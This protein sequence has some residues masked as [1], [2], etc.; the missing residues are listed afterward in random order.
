LT[1]IAA[2]PDLR[3]NV[4][5][6]AGARAVPINFTEIGINLARIDWFN[7]GRNYDQLVQEAANEA[8][9]NAFV[10]EYAR[11]G[12]TGVAWFTTSGVRAALENATGGMDVLN[13]LRGAGF[14]PTG[15]L[16]QVL[17][18]HIPLPATLAAQGATEGAFYTSPW[19]FTSAT[20]APFDKAAFMA[21][22]ETSVLGPLD[23]LR[24]TFERVPYLTRLGT[25][26]SPDEMNVD[27]LFVPNASLPEVAP[28]HMAVGHV[29][30]GDEDHSSC[31]APLRLEIED[32]RSVLFRPNGACRQYD[33]AA[34]DQMPASDVGFRRDPDGEGTREVDNRAAIE[35]AVSKHNSAVS[36]MIDDGCGCT[37]RGKGR[38]RTLLG[39]AALGLLAL[40]LRRRIG[41]RR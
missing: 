13:A 12:R 8:R 11:G 7:F 2:T 26:I 32:G 33:R 34:L 30:C 31:D 20:F 19:M 3:I 18:K 39:F 25:F 22:L 17:R 37:M 36:A 24:P 5:V 29:L 38:V 1:A 14:Q 21:D 4:W 28:Q 40:R 10:V 16:L 41:G 23:T 9:G 6:L 35:K 15:A 27:P